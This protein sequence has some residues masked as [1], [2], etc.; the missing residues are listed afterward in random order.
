MKKFFILFLLFTLVA[1]NP[2]AETTEEILA[3]NDSVVENTEEA[4]TDQAETTEEIEASEEIE[5][6]EEASEETQASEETDTTEEV[7]EETEASEE[8]DTTEEATEETEASEETDTTE[9]AT[10]EEDVQYTQVPLDPTI[11]DDNRPVVTIT[12]DNDAVIKFKMVP[13]VAP[14]H[15]NAFIT[16]A[17]EGYYDGLIFHRII[18]GFMIQGGDPLGTGAGGPGYTLDNEFYQ[19]EDTSIIFL[20]HY[21]GVVSMART[22]APNSAG[23]QFFIMHQDYHRLNGQ[24]SSFG[25]V[26]EGM[27]F[28]DA[29]ASVETDQNDRPL[30]EVKMK[31]VTVELN[32]YEV[33]EPIKN[34]E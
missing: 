2:V 7:S 15:V 18:E 1:C 22:S 33:E 25:Y 9:E 14:N 21:R 31:S 11:L 34:V 26:I 30:Q 29:F 17:Q 23:S 3:I 12:F 24:Y 27:D 8:T 19:I 10:E 16:L 4:I 32:G 28:V 6:T 5:T 13:E 20:P